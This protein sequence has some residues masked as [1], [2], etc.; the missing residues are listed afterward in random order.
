MAR[1]HSIKP[2]R[3]II[4]LWNDLQT[5]I[6]LEFYSS[7]PFYH[8]IKE[9]DLQH[10][11]NMLIDHVRFTRLGEVRF[12]DIEAQDNNLAV[13]H[14]L[15]SYIDKDNRS[16]E[17][18]VA[19]LV[20]AFCNTQNSEPNLV[21]IIQDFVDLGCD[22]QMIV[23]MLKKKNVEQN[24]NTNLPVTDKKVFISH[25]SKDKYIIK[26]FIDDILKKGIGLRDENIICTSFESTGVK[27]GQDIKKY[28]D[29]NIKQ[30]CIFLSMI[31]RSYKSSEVCMNEVGA[32]WAVGNIPI[33]IVLPDTDFSSLGWLFHL[34]KAIKINDDSALD[35]LMEVVC[36]RCSIDVI[37]PKHWNPN[38]ADFL[39]S[40]GRIAPEP[41]NDK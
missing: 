1:R 41:E 28:I 2:K 5:T 29:E 25:S 26:C 4:Q 14:M 9:A 13:L 17:N 32:A 24:Y 10:A 21:Q 19:G 36:E 11:W 40:L 35:S 6:P 31:S 12:G 34:D 27:P 15:N 38:K 16:F 18:M 33:Q 20:Q 8:W 23:N 37:K 39:N 3:K 22:E 30:S 7:E